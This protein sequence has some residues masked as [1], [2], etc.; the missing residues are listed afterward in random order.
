ME[1]DICPKADS[2]PLLLATSRA[3]AF[4]DRVG[5][6][7][8]KQQS[9]LTVIFKLVIDGLS[10]TILVVS[11]TVSLQFQSSISQRNGLFPFL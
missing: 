2:P 11:G 6:Y 9:S 5:G 3:G 4:I 1:V 10:S 7:M 8:Q